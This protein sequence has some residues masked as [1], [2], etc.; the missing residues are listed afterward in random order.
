MLFGTHIYSK[1][2]ADE[3]YVEI[4]GPWIVAASF[5]AAQSYCDAFLE[6]YI[7]GKDVLYIFAYDSPLIPFNQS[8]N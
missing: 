2:L 7:M 3:T 8:W 6:E 1:N 5:E 4:I